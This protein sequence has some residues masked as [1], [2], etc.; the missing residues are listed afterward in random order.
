LLLALFLLVHPAEAPVSAE[1]A[2]FRS[3]TVI[4]IAGHRAE[5]SALVLFLR[6]GGQVI[7]ER[8][9]LDRIEP[10][11]IA[12]D[13]PDQAAALGTPAREPRWGAALGSPGAAAAAAPAL[14]DPPINRPRRPRPY[15]QIIA[16]VSQEHGVNP[17]LVHALIQVESGYRPH[18]RSPKGAMGLMQ[19]MPDT[20]GR[21]AV[22]D[23]FD[24]I[25]NVRGGTRHLKH[26]LDKFGIRGALA[27]YNA[28]EGVVRKFQ[29]VPPYRE[30][31]KFVTRIL[32]IMNAWE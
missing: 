20:V 15:A 10:D 27:A 7:C 13:L 26:L 11:E 31:Q 32:E 18:A 3:G 28:G 2:F 30:T 17:N 24:P 25:A 14:I 1:L 4:S 22:A 5:G 29:G 19:L 8:T 12:A 16:R 6:N 23:P 9:L 21:Y